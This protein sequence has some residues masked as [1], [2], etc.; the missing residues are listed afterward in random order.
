MSPNAE[1]WKN[2]SVLGDI[3]Y[4][5]RGIVVGRDESG[6]HLVQVYWIMGRSENSRNRI[7]DNDGGRVFTAA[8][9]PSKVQ[10]PSLII[11]NAMDECPRCRTFF[12]V[13]NGHQTD[14][15]RS[16]CEQGI[17]SS[18]AKYSYEP[19]APNYTPR[20]NGFCDTKSGLG[21]I[22]GL[23]I[24]RKSPLGGTCERSIYLYEQIANG[25]GYC[26][27]TYADD[28]SPLPS[29]RGEPLLM[30]LAGSLEGV[31]DQYWAILNGENLVSLVVKFI[32]VSSGKSHV[33]IINK[34]L[35]V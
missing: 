32:E 3:C 10:D 8:A 16:A 4:P 24:I 1:A 27:T 17:I 20:I 6:Q 12:A 7:F 34:Y 2:L 35:R 22:A 28:G 25:F 31:A 21:T 26:I 11:Y 23:A 5:G 18:L 29:F 15:F 13:T 9:N 30:P 14:S 33:S 19:D